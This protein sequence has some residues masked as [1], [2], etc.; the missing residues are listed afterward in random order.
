MAT[1]I[2]HELQL[3]KVC[4]LSVDQL[5]NVLLTNHIVSLHVLQHFPPSNQCPRDELLLNIVIQQ[6]L[7]IE[8]RFVKHTHQDLP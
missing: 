1:H 6:L 4:P 3:V 2:F 7:E 5:A 8:I